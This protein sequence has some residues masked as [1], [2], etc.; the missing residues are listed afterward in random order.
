MPFSKLSQAALL[1]AEHMARKAL[2]PLP[3]GGLLGT[4]VNRELSCALAQGGIVQAFLL[5]EQLPCQ[6]LTLAS[7]WNGAAGPSAI[8]ALLHTALHRAE[9]TLPP[10]TPMSVQSV[11]Q[12]SARLIRKLVPE[13]MP[14]S[15][16]WYYFLSQMS[17][18]GDN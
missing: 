5:F 1:E 2:I 3:E 15:M 11:N 7:A 6:P 17:Q 14:V 18:K 8:P 10:E 4:G 9:Q 13:A 12:A 16:S